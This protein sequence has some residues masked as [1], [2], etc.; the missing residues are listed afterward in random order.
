MTDGD[1]SLSRIED[2]AEYWDQRYGARLW[3]SEPD[4]ILVSLAS[5]L[6]AGTALDLGCGTGRNSVWLAS[7]GW[8]VQGVDISQVGLSQ[9][10]RISVDAGVTLS[11]LRADI[12]EFEPEPGLYDLVV[13]A[14][15]HFP[16]SSAHELFA[17]VQTAVA[18][19]GHL[20]V[21]GRHSD[22]ARTAEE[23]ALNRF[24]SEERL[25]SLFP[26]MEVLEIGR[27]PGRGGYPSKDVDKVYLWARRSDS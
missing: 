10:S 20:F 19:G 23:C 6:M 14:N 1:Q 9:A 27:V 26:A 25:E 2:V 22:S 16:Q 24:Y 12:L 8:S 18:I 13:L 15:L 3:P 5:E 17:R 21:I 4:T 7:M 11:F